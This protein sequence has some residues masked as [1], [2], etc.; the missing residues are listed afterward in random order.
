[1]FAAENCSVNLEAS[2]IN[3]RC[4]GLPALMGAEEEVL[5]RMCLNGRLLTSL[6]R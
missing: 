1:M 2:C 5:S 3:P 6:T 4:D